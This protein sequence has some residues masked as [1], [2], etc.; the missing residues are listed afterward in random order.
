MKTAKRAVYFDNASTSFP[1]APGVGT[2]MA[3]YLETRGCNVG[4][5]N[6][7]WGYEVAEAVYQARKKLCELFG[8]SQGAD[9][10]KNVVFTG[11]VTEALN[12]VITGLLK[13]GDHVLV[14]GLEHNAVMRPL[15]FLE[16]QGI[17]FDVI[18]CD[19][20]GK[21][22]VE[23]IEG[24]IQKNTKAI[25]MTHGSNVCGTILP[26]ERVAE[27][28]QRYRLKLVVDA[29]Q[30]AGI[31]PIDLTK[32]HI[33]ALCFTG[34]KGLLGPQGIGGLIIR[35]ELA[36]EISGLIMGGTGSRSESFEMPDFLPDKLESGTLNIPGIYGLSKAL[37][38]LKETGLEIILEKEMA[39]TK[40]LITGI[41]SLKTLELI[42]IPEIQGRSA[43]ISV[44]C[45]VKDNAQVAFELDQTYGIMTRVGLHCAPLAHR[46]L[47]T[48]PHGTIRLALGHFNTAE[49]V[50]YCLNALAA[51]TTG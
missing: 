41:L 42:G 51:I 29:A 47:G 4:R 26:I 39:L 33:D 49:E 2:A 13:P 17:A 34:H 10:T 38:Y 50:D 44:V 15:F 30:T 20:Q 25:I 45:K 28:C 32:T 18:P 19:R 46:T 31:F 40:K 8:F 35:D 22:H 43:V 11:S 14:S 23:Q 21:L 12:L 27:I 36:E 37:D 7:Q 9:P 48:Y 5:G 1:K 6:Y 3:T 16:N 24:L